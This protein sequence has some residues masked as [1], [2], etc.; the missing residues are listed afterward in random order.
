MFEYKIVDSNRKYNDINIE[1]FKNLEEVTEYKM[2][3]N[4]MEIIQL[5][6]HSHEKNEYKLKINLP[7]GMDHKIYKFK[8]NLAYTGAPFEPIP[9]DS[10]EDRILATD[11][12]FERDLLSME[13]QEFNSFII[14]IHSK[15]ASSGKAE[16]SINGESKEIAFEIFDKEVPNEKFDIELWQYPY[17]VAEYYRVEPFTYEHE[18]LLKKH[19]LNYKNIGGDAIVCSIAEDAWDGQTYSKNEIHFPSMIKWELEEDEMNYD[20]SHFDSWIRI[21]NEIGLGQKKIVL[22]GMAPWH[23]SFTY[24]RDGK[25]VIEK[26]EDSKDY[27]EKWADFLDKL[28]DH[29]DNLN[30]LDR[31]FIGIDE[32]G[33]GDEIFKILEDAEKRNGKRLKVSAAIDNFQE[34]SKYSDRID[35]VSVALREYE[36]DRKAYFEYANNRRDLGFKTT[37]YSCVGHKPGNYALSH[38][39]ETLYTIINSAISDGFLRWAYDAWVKNPLEDS[40]HSAFEPGDCFLVYPGDHISIRLLKIK[41]AIYWVN[42][43][44]TLYNREELFNILDNQRTKFVTQKE[45]LTPDLVEKLI[46]DIEEIRG[47]ID[48]TMA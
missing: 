33:F 27:A 13:K 36:K 40:T 21:C 9:M 25:L 34:N 6:I 48:E 17:S 11:I 15:K 4:D 35:Y 26:F 23:F 46:K 22:Y 39:G 30:I 45:Y 8:K 43:L 47:L 7:E 42:K 24:Y 20:F 31:V 16:I 10:K 14:E 41:E 19:L 5:L 32:R 38:P 3:K 18:I 28:Y 12:L 37:L 44:R 29:L 2:W 1:E